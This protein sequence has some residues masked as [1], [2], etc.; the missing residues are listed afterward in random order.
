MDIALIGI[1]I[2]IILLYF[3]SEWM[4][5][6][7][8]KIALLLGISPFVI[9]LTVL[10]FGSSAPEAI[11]SVV[12]RGTPS[13]II[14]NVV[15]SNI[16]NIGLAIGLAAIICPL[17]CSFKDTKIEISAMIL[18]DLLMSALA[19][20]GSIGSLSGALLIASI[21]IF[22]YL[23]YR[24]RKDDV[25]DEEPEVVNDPLWKCIVMTVLGLALLYF[26]SEAFIGGAKAAATMLGVSDLLVGLI[27]VAI[28]TSLPELCICLMAAY[29]RETDL[30]VSNI[31][32]SN[33]FNCLFVLGVGA[34]LTDIPITDTV[35]TFHLPVMIAM[36]LIMCAF[37]YRNDG[38]GKKAG[39]VLT[40]MYMAYIAV[41]ALNPAL[42]L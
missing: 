2:G 26:G 41:I 3:G 22:V 14:G 6:G 30:A 25:H 10:A 40:A 9:G 36:T 28:G 18:S 31:V 23:V 29:R 15:G 39:F 19:I 37:I 35:I 1:P 16:A 20:T 17:A 34:L 27:V 8:K 5:D 32:G 7:A 42:T 38:I 4:V 24:L 21:F 33:I 11:T 13:L 12:S